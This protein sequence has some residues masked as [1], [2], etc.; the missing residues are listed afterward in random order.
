MVMQGVAGNQIVNRKR[1]DRRWH[2]ELNYDLDQFENRWTGEA[3]L[4]NIC[5]RKVL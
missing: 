4:T 5:L 1:G 2:S 3:L